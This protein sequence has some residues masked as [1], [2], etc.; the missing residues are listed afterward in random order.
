[1]PPASLSQST[2][3]RA[4][5]CSPA[6]SGRICPCHSTSGAA[7]PSESTPEALQWS[8]G[9]VE[10]CPLLPILFPYFL[11]SSLTLSQ[12]PDFMDTAT[13][14]AYSCH[15][16]LTLAV[17]LSNILPNIRRVPSLTPWLTPSSLLKNSETPIRLFF[18]YSQAC[19]PSYFILQNT[20]F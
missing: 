1:M 10:T 13:H 16:P 6:K 2:F 5:A 7:T 15:R 20:R 17:P 3:S 8:A 4:A 11:P 18:L 14:Q 12:A 19:F 9:S